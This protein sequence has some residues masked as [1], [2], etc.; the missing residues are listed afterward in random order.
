MP[1]SKQKVK[2]NLQNWKTYFSSKCVLEFNIRT[3]FY[4]LEF[5]IRTSKKSTYIEFEYV[6]QS[7]YIEFKYVFRV[8]RKKNYS[9]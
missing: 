5:D 4:V 8:L 9:S 1:Y 6:K 3:L 7:T 2:K